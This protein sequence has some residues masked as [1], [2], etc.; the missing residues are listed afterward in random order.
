MLIQ[1][2][3]QDEKCAK[4]NKH[5][6]VV[7]T[8][9]QPSPCVLS[10]TLLLWQWLL[11]GVLE[12]S[13]A[14]QVALGTVGQAVP[15]WGAALLELCSPLPHLLPSLPLLCLALVCVFKLLLLVY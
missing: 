10:R 8:A 2:K 15:S 9:T 7:P 1:M 3:Q 12:C 11:R 5:K 13:R 14:E 4:R 6:V